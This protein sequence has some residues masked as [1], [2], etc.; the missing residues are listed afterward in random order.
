LKG[1]GS[2]GGVDGSRG[3]AKGENE[4]PFD[5]LSP[6]STVSGLTGGGAAD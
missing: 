6:L 3:V 5:G 2:A 1:G 4:S